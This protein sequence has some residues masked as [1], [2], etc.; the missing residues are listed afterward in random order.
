MEESLGRE[1]NHNRNRN[2]KAK[3]TFV[4]FLSL[5]KYDRSGFMIQWSNLSSEARAALRSV[6]DY[7][8]FSAEC[9]RCGSM[10]LVSDWDLC[11]IPV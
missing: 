1:E 5:K 8:I 6:D 3:Q 2:R 7:F 11:L 9:L 10:A 4:I